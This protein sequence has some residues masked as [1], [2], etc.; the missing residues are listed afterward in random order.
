MFFQALC[1][2]LG[3][4]A[5]AHSAPGK[6][7]NDS[8]PAVDLGY[9]VHVPTS[10]K[11]A[12]SGMSYANYDNIR[13]AQPPLGD[14]RFRRPAPPLPQDGIQN[15][16]ADA[17]SVSCVSS[18]PPDFPYASGNRTSWGREDCLFLNVRVPEGI[19]PGEKVPVLH[20]LYGS[21]YSIG[22]KDLSLDSI[23]VYNELYPPTQ[24][25]IQVASNYRLACTHSSPISS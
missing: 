19:K 12:E 15:G 1:F 13:F 17:Y 6:Y 24:K 11:Q 10:M 16:S 14:L 9:A 3:G 7:S 22:S 23:G 25:Y 20:W 18:A 21:A 5:L 8:F 2:L 4:A